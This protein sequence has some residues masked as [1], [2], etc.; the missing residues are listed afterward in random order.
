MRWV[1]LV[2][3]AAG[4]IIVGAL[5]TAVTFAARDGFNTV[6]RVATLVSAATAVASL[7]VT[8]WG[9]R[10]PQSPVANVARRPIRR[11]AVTLSTVLIAL[12]IVVPPLVIAKP[13]SGSQV[14][15]S[16]GK[17]PKSI[18]QKT[19]L[20][21]N[22][23]VTVFGVLQNG[24]IYIYPHTNPENGKVVWGQKRYVGSGWHIGR[25]LAGPGGFVYLMV[26][27]TGEL[28]R[29]R[30]NGDGWDSFDGG[31]QYRV[32]GNGWSRYSQPAYR[33]KVTVD[34][35]GR[36]YEIDAEGH[37]KV[38][39]SDAGD[40]WAPEVGGGR[41]LATG[42]NQ[43]DLLVAAGDGVLYARK[44]NGDLSRFRYHA[45][46]G[47][48]VQHGLLVGQGWQFYNHIFSPGGDILYGTRPEGDGELVWYRYLESTNTLRGGEVI[49]SEWYDHLDVVATTDDCKL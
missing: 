25:T 36:L 44:P 13:W 5:S 10:R 12:A 28:R 11:I 19:H 29:Y 48:F 40:D 24:T 41:V 27:D 43:Y 21:C 6:S 32:V 46:S 8:V 15:A 23:A 18:D 22:A 31:G 20:T 14:I 4:C 26:A 7:I 30:W 16:P 42:W 35:K 34:E 33:N 38:F 37:L 45:S 1:T 3:I 47:Q 17:S 49:G 2:G 39:F 9:L